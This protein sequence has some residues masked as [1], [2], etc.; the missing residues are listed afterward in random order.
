MSFL[1]DFI[2]FHLFSFD[3]NFD[4]DFGNLKSKKYNCEVRLQEGMIVNQAF[5]PSIITPKTKESQ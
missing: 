1:R 3:K 5:D 2:P 4:D